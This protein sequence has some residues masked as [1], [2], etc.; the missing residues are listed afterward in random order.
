MT[1]VVTAGTERRRS[2]ADRS[3]ETRAKLLKATIDL[4]IERGYARLSTNDVAA[5][6]GLSR[7]AQVH[8]FPLKS[9][10]VT[11]AIEDLVRQY[12]GFLAARIKNLP[13]GRAGIKKV[14]DTL[15]EIYSS[16]LHDAYQELHVAARTDPE[17]RRSEKAMVAAIVWPTLDLVVEALVGPVARQDTALQERITAAVALVSGLADMRWDRGSDW[18]ERQLTLVVDWLEPVVLEARSRNVSA[19]KAPKSKGEDREGDDGGRTGRGEG[20]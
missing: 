5:R 2:Q 19:V 15:F 3:A 9:D 11:A 1:K 17:L 10:L 16:P 8:H 4:L 12:N 14:I 18:C 13:E 7:G 6:I 20:V